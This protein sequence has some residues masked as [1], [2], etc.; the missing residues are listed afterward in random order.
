M[1]AWTDDQTNF[2]SLEQDAL[3]WLRLSLPNY[4]RFHEVDGGHLPQNFVF[5]DAQDPVELDPRT[6]GMHR[7]GYLSYSVFVNLGLAR[8]GADETPDVFANLLDV[9]DHVSRVAL[10][11]GAAIDIAENLEVNHRSL[12]GGQNG[13]FSPKNCAKEHAKLKRSLQ[14]TIDAYNN[15]LK[16]NG[17]PSLRLETTDQGSVAVLVPEKLSLAS[18]DP[19]QPSPWKAM[20]PTVRVREKAQQAISEALIAFEKYFG[21]LADT[22]PDRHRDWKAQKKPTLQGVG[23]FAQVLDG[24]VALNPWTLGSGSLGS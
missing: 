20:S 3:G 18:L 8:R 13:L 9:Y 15:Y 22:T 7:I 10:R 5:D 19:A 2:D 6:S 17:L 24:Y 4:L 1:S 12:Y 21:A 16:H 14:T 11:L 23:A